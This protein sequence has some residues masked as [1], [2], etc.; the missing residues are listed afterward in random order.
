[1]DILDESGRQV[2]NQGYV[3]STKLEAENYTDTKV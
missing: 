1:M 3:D 2:T